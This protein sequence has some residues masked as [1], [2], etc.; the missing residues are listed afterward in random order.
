MLFLAVL[1][2]VGAALGLYFATGHVRP[3][4]ATHASQGRGPVIEGGSLRVVSQSAPQVPLKQIAAAPRRVPRRK[5][6]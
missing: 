1:V 5:Q 2:E 3:E 6:V 4:G